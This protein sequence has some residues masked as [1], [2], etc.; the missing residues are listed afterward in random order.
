VIL[1]ATGMTAEARLMAGP[2]IT[3]I[4]GGG[5]GERLERALD[6]TATGARL[7]V[8]S[9]LAGAVSPQ[10]KVGDV[11]IDGPE[12]LV[13]HL[14][15][16]V[17]PR[18]ARGWGGMHAGPVIGRDHPIAT[19]QDKI[20]AGRD[21]ALAVDMESHIARRVAARHGLPWLVVRVISDG[22]DRTLPPAALVGMRPDGGIA[23][24]AVLASLTRHPGQLP[25]LVRTA[26]DANQAMRA[27][28][29]VHD[30]LRRV[31]IAGL[32]PGQFA[33]D[34]G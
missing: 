8:S 2:G 4:A 10:L 20:A 31:G 13:A 18:S 23:L 3:V 9:G 25:A 19:V 33:L 11:V 21:G 28:G 26:R 22:A 15:E 34:V 5:N 16:N 32:D 24:G 12:G 29:G 27:L 1:I 14:L 17:P 7:I 30:A 6:A